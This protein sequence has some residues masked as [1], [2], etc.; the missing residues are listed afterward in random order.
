MAAPAVGAEHRSGSTDPVLVEVTR[1]EVVENRQQG[2][3]S[4]LKG[5]RLPGDST[6]PAIA[7]NVA[8]S[9]FDPPCTIGDQG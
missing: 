5:R 7:N 9:I 4:A 6:F 2:L 8:V 1:G 3:A